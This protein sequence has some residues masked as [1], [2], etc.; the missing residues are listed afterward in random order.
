[1]RMTALRLAAL[2]GAMSTLAG[3]ATATGMMY[4]DDRLAQL[5]APQFSLRAHEIT[6]S[7]REPTATGTYYDA[8]LPSGGK[9]RCFHDGNIM[10]LGLSNPPRCGSQMNQNPLT[11][12]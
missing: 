7:N 6:I 1:M 11:G 4:S 10:G 9:V 5:T 2:V 3:C 12:R 8:A